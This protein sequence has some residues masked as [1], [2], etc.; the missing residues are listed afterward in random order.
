MNTS[1]LSRLI[2]SDTALTGFSAADLPLAAKARTANVIHSGANLWKGISDVDFCAVKKW[3]G[4]K[5]IFDL[6]VASFR[7]GECCYYVFSDGSLYFASSGDS[8]VWADA[9]DFAV[10]RIVNGYE[11]PLDEMDAGLLN[12]LGGTLAEAAEQRG[13]RA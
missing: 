1:L 11:G 8:E 13:I 10:E 2:K 6:A 5:E 12:H 9:S 4:G 3:A 7:E